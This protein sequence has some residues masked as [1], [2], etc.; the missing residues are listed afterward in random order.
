M[1]QDSERDSEDR[2]E[3]DEYA[4]WD[5]FGCG[6][7]GGVVFFDEDE[8][9]IQWSEWRPET[10][11]YVAP[12][13]DARSAGA[14]L[15]RW[16][17]RLPHVG[18][19]VRIFARCTPEGEAVTSLAMHPDAWRHWVALAAD[20]EKYRRMMAKRQGRPGSEPEPESGKEPGRW[21]RGR[22]PRSRL[23]AW[24]VAAAR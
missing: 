22:C 13:L 24:G 5:G 23:A 17:R 19:Q 3:G 11:D 2:H 9:S 15:K 7:D 18:T 1:V 12:T 16:L 6:P 21:W 20:G 8:F 4:A 10:D 14:L